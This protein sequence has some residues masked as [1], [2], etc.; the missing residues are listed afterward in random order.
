VVIGRRRNLFATGGRHDIRVMGDDPLQALYDQEAFAQL[1]GYARKMVEHARRR[2]IDVRVLDAQASYLVLSFGGRRIV[3][4]G[5]LSELTSAVAAGWCQDKRLTR[6]L[7]AAAK[8][9]VPRGRI[10]TFDAADAQFLHSVGE[11]VVKPT[12]SEQGWGVTVGVRDPEGL[13]RARRLAQQYCPSVVLEE[14]CGGQDLRIVVIDHQ[15]VAAAVRHLPCI[16]GNGRD[17]IAQLIRQRSAQREAETG[18]EFRIP[19][20]DHVRDTVA[21]AGYRLDDVLTKGV[22]LAVRR[23][24]NLHTGGTIE[25]V[26]PSLHPSLARVAVLASKTLQIP[27][28]GI[29]LLVPSINGEEYVIIEANERPGLDNHQ[30]QPT[31]ERFLDLLFP[32]TRLSQ[33]VI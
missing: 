17:T 26:T 32:E 29:D 7:L 12:N 30:P 15:V 28:V 14:Y 4:R 13:E 27:V 6:K 10:A 33:V 20:D 18:G 24:A 1:D 19:V 5:S 3:T 21:Q 31:Y 23:N 25:D 9:R 16:V 11:I 8:L 22:T 2:G